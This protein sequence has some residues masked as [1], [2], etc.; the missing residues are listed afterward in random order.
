MIATEQAPA[1][2]AE[3]AAQT[4]LPADRYRPTHDQATA[5]SA[6]SRINIP[7]NLENWKH[8]PEEIVAD[9]LWFHQYLLDAKK[10]WQEGIEAIN[11]D[12]STL[13]RV[14]KGSYEGNWRN[15]TTAIQS[16]KRIVSERSTIKKADW[17]ENSITRL[18]F[19][20]LNYAM[21][22]QSVTIII[23]ESRMGK[24]AAATAWRNLNNH[25]RSCMVIAPAYG[26]TKALL[27]D[28]A[29]TVG[30]NKNTS[31]PA[32]HEAVLRAFNPNRILIV[33]EAHRLLPCDRR[34]NPVNLEIL[35]DIHDRTG[36]ALALLATQRFDLELKKS[37]Y[38]FEQLI[39]RVGM[40]VRLPRKVKPADIEPIVRQ[41]ISRPG[42]KLMQ[43]A[44]QVANDRGRLG[45][46]VETLK[47]ASRM[48]AKDDSKMNEEHFFKALAFRQR[49]SGEL[50]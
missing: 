27:R 39:G 2:P 7:L 11:Y 25:G 31:V 4:A 28:I 1:K 23:G 21:A 19:A 6:H 38:M 44:E 13:F 35:R 32:M 30:V 49:M 34:S 47:V 29:G 45:I 3:T 36:C 16:Y 20:G 43:A 14:L 12:R 48:A 40:P 24:T 33:D 22:N 42:Q 50:Q 8:L 26:G 18:I 5:S 10:T 41:Y 46:L 15:I 9:L 37:E 17:V